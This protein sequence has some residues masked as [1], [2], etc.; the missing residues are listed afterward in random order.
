MKRTLV[1]T[2]ACL[3]L[4]SHPALA[5]ADVDLVENPEAQ[6]MGVDALARHY[7]AIK[8]QHDLLMIV[9]TALKKAGANPAK[10]PDLPPLPTPDAEGA[11]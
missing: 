5:Q 11:P 4:L 3:L 10:P 2:A 1:A 7:E 6:R 8:R 9:Y